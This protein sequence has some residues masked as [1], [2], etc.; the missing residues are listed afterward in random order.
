MVPIAG[1][2]T[3]T[4]LVNVCFFIKF[5]VEPI[6]DNRFSFGCEKFK[7]YLILPDRRIWKLWMNL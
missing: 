7:R 4:I 6:L 3:G 1:R 5:H 2:N